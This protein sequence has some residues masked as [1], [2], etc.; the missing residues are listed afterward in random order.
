MKSASKEKRHRFVGLAKSILEFD[1][2]KSLGKIACPTLVLGAKKDLVLGVDGV[3]ELANNIPRASYYE[4]GKLG[5]R[6]LYRK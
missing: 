6:G 5:S 3:R 2:Y 1:C 4:F